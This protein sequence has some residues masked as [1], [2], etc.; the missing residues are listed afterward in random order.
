[1]KGSGASL[2]PW[3]WVLG[4]HASFQTGAC[5]EEQ[6]TNSNL[7]SALPCPAEAAGWPCMYWVARGWAWGLG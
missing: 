3:M 1:M 4:P 6:T 7:L 2:R 5:A